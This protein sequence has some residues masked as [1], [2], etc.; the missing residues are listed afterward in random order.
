MSDNV[1]PP[2]CPGRFYPAEREQLRQQVRGYI[3]GADL[4][5]DVEPRAVIAPHAGYVFSG[6]VAGHAFA[7]LTEVVD[8]YER[9]VL[10]GPSHFVDV[11]GLAAPSHEAFRTPLGEVSVDRETV[12]SLEVGGIDRE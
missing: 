4:S 7:G 8:R 9:V 2:A 1:R 6:P 10:V 12:E 5:M 3:D 11:S